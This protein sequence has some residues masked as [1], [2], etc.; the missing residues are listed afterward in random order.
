M[1]DTQQEDLHYVSA[2]FQMVAIC[3]TTSILC[4]LLYW[5]YT[6]Y[7]PLEQAPP[8]KSFTP[9]QLVSFGSPSD[10]QTGVYVKDF[11]SNDLEAGTMT[12][13]MLV[14]FIF[15]PAFVAFDRISKFTFANGTIIKP[16][17]LVERQAQAGTRIVDEHRLIARFDVRVEFRLPLQYDLFPLD[18]HYVPF[19]LINDFARPQQVVFHSVRENFVVQPGLEAF[20]WRQV[21]T[22][23]RSG[24]QEHIIDNSDPSKTTYTPQVVFSINY[25]RIGVRHIISILLPLLLIFF[26]SLFAFSFDTQGA[27]GSQ[28][29]GFASG[30]ITAMM[31]YYYVIQSMSPKI[32]YFMIS[33]YLY[34]LFLLLNFIVFLIVV[35]KTHL[36]TWYKRALVLLF[37]ATV[38]IAATYLFIFWLR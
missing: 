20:G 30:G 7:A 17:D 10:V 2:S 26:V 19:V 21:D 25:K 9:Q 24:F 3:I 11:V 15:D 14:W 33:D 16:D 5:P 12:L 35:F 8:L 18:D 38:I 27:H 36:T 29:F 1:A 22:D 37:H 32:S 23:V 6:Q 4:L 34:F 28:A 13:D 31:A